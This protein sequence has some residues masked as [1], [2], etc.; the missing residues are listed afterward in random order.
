MVLQRGHD[1]RQF[2]IIFIDLSELY[3]KDPD[4]LKNKLRTRNEHD[5]QQQGK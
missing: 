2:N 3:G 1:G 4:N 5:K